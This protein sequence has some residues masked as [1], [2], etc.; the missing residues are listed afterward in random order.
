MVVLD[1]EYIRQQQYAHNIQTLYQCDL[2][3]NR[4]RDENG[5]YCWRGITQKRPDC[6]VADTCSPYSYTDARTAF[7][8]Q[9]GCD[10]TLAVANP[11]GLQSPVDNRRGGIVVFVDP[12]RCEG[13]VD[14]AGCFLDGVV[15]SFDKLAAPARQDETLMSFA[16]L[17]VL[18]IGITL[19]FAVIPH[20]RQKSKAFFKGF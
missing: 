9:F 14:T 19:Y 4:F 20:S 6:V 1:E 15:Q 7:C 8:V 3:E 12:K 10:P 2:E 13:F 5:L 18:G 11:E 17:T 16:I